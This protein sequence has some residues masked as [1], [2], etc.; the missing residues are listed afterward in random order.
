MKLK[1]EELGRPSKEEFAKSS[2]LPVTVIL[3]NV[4][5]LHNVGSIFRTCDAFAVERLYLC[6]ITAIPP[7]REIEKAALGATETVSWQ[8]W[9][10]TVEAVR[11]LKEKG[12][13][14]IAAEQVS[15][16]IPPKEFSLQHGRRY[17]VIFGH[18]VHGVTQDVL[19]LCDQFVEIPQSGTKHSLNVAVSSGIVLWEMFSRIEHSGGL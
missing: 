8:H 17:A 13:Y 14:I 18:E 19:D 15:G 2:R 4:R 5:S 1:M 7:N 12:Y 10:E 6:G 3:D 11:Y 9:S 16:S